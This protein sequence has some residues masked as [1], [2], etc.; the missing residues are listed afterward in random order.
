[1]ITIKT[2]SK[3]PI[4][5][6]HT[7]L[8][9]MLM[10][11]CLLAPV[12]SQ[13][14]PTT[15][16]LNIDTPE[17]S[18][19]QAI[20]RW[21]T[22]SSDNKNSRSESGFVDFLRHVKA[23]IN[24]S[25]FACALLKDETV[26][27]W[28]ENGSGVLGNGSTEDSYIPVKVANIKNVKQIAA[29]NE[30]ACATTDN[31]D[32]YCWGSNSHGQLGSDTPEN[33]SAVP[34][35]IDGL[36][37]E[38]SSIHAGSSHTCAI[39]NNN[40]LNC[41]GNN[42]SGQ[43]GDGTTESTKTPVKVE[44]LDGDVLSVSGSTDA[45]CATLDSGFVECWGSNRYG[46]LGIGKADDDVHAEPTVTVGLGNA[47]A[48]YSASR[49]FTMCATTS[50]WQAWCWGAGA[51]GQ[52][53]N[54]YQLPNDS[55]QPARVQIKGK[56]KELALSN[57]HTCALLGDRVLCW[58]QNQTGQ[59]GNGYT[60]N[61]LLE[62]NKML[63]VSAR[64][65]AISASSASDMIAAGFANTCVVIAD[66]RVK[67]TGSNSGGQLGIG[68]NQS[69]V[70]VPNEVPGLRE[71][72]VPG[73][74]EDF[75]CSLSKSGT[76]ACWGDN[77]SGQLGQGNFNKPQFTAK[78]VK[79]L[80]GNIRALTVGYHHACVITS[81]HGV[82]CWGRNIEG[83]VGNGSFQNVAKPVDVIGLETGVIAIS[84]GGYHTCAVTNLGSVK[85]WG[86]NKYG[87]VGYPGAASPT[88]VQVNGLESGALSVGLGRSTSCAVVST[89]I[90][91]W[92]DNHWGQLGANYAE[93]NTDEPQQVVGVGPGVKSLS[94]GFGHTC[95]IAESGGALC[96]GLNVFGELGN[97]SID[98]DQCDDGD[99]MKCPRHP[100][101]ESVIGLSSSTSGITA[102]GAHTCA[103]TESGQLY[104]WGA[105]GVGQLGNDSKEASPEPVLVKNLGPIKD[106]TAG[107]ASTCA[108]LRNGQSYCWGNNAGGQLGLGWAS[109]VTKAVLV[110][111]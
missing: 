57:G 79:G 23:I 18:A 50:D 35:K 41:W 110:E 108:T 37:Q 48:V 109:Y 98:F 31:G 25:K 66:G 87:Q 7:L 55:P 86:F 90:K 77:S 32:G 91:C 73:Q 84:A 95:A 62:P 46:Q 99:L 45:T 27:C 80:G 34:V 105:G 42:E 20:Q 58:G 1:M 76:V 94:G 8:F 111:R 44:G 22:A 24:G 2:F 89:G 69:A 85:C 72:A 81:K 61:I 15:I 49:G 70:F 104:C 10:Y 12:C 96:W 101:P 30:H 17:V 67:C 102:G 56:V 68:T 14:N 63:G 107:D 78:Q 29:G 65:K 82:K 43:L 39:L 88:P 92:G 19:E 74:G 60:G 21:S 83:Q 47:T 93:D 28:G 26:W 59:L 5:S 40:S 3:R 53:G 103:W 36:D 97:G 71:Q 6:I 13:A 52:L 106:G 4:H 75:G 51:V 11:L 16:S 38:I 100:V 33:N 64:P 54:G 9:P